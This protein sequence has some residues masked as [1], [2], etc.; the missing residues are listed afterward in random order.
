MQAP[1]D[2]GRAAGSGMGARPRQKSLFAPSAL[3]P[4][5]FPAVTAGVAGR[6]TER[7]EDQRRSGLTS[8]LDIS[9]RRPVF[10]QARGGGRR[11]AGAR[12]GAGRGG[13]GGRRGGG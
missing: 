2:A 13:G 7:S 9:P 11:R 12:G 4:F 6:E 3:F 1:I 8:S 10:R 5:F